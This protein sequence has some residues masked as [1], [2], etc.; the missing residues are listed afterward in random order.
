MVALN[1]LLAPVLVLQVTVPVGVDV[2]PESVSVT[3]AVQVVVALTAM[4]LVQ[5]TEDEVERLFTV[6]EK[7]PELVAWVESPP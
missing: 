5:L 2:V 6:S 1:W 3:V 4:G 7:V